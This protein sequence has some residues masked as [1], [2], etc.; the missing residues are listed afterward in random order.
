VRKLLALAII[1]GLAVLGCDG[2]P[3]TPSK[4]APSPPA[5]AGGTETTPKGKDEKGSEKKEEKPPK[6]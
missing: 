5:K 4:K 3:S 1:S 6:G 2:N